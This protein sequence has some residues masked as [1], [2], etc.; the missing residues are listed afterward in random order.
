MTPEEIILT[1]FGL[2][3]PVAAILWIRWLDARLDREDAQ[4]P[5]E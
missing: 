1:L 3:V 5:A 2:A 4:G